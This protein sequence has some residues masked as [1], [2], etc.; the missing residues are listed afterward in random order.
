MGT[1]LADSVIVF[2]TF[3]NLEKYLTKLKGSR[4]A[5]SVIVFKNSFVL[6][7]YNYLIKYCA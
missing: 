4:L 1:Y 2:E 3:L 6:K 7:I 5:N